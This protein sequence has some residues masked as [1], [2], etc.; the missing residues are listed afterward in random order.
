MIWQLDNFIQDID[1]IANQLVSQGI[2][3]S[4]FYQSSF[5]EMQTALNAKSR[6]DRVQDP[7]ELARQI[8]AL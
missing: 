3:P 4:D 6:K 5:S 2:L 8:G 7:L 1:Y